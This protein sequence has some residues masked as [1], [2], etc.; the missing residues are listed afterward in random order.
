MTDKELMQQALE[1]LELHAKQYPHMVKGYTADA[2]TALRERLAQW[3][4]LDRM[5]ANARKLGLNYEPVHSTQISKIW[6]DLH[7]DKLMAERIDP[8]KIYQK[9]QMQPCAG[10]NCG[11]TNSNLHS[12]E[13]FEDYDKATGGDSNRTWTQAHWTEYERSIAAQER[14]ACAKV[15]TANAHMFATPQAAESLANAI[16][17]RGTT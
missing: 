3:D 5:A 12:A 6:W 14:E 4:A 8:A 15:V 16:R 9:P 17:A 7:G 11:S 10:R 2:A 1:A 13:C